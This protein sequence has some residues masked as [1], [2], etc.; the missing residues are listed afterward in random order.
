MAK[1]LTTQQAKFCANY[2]ESGNAFE[3]A[4][5]A[6]YSHST[7]NNATA[8]LIRKNK[9]IAE[10]IEKSQQDIIKASNWNKARIISELESIYLQAKQA[11]Q[12][13]NASKIL[14]LL[15]KLC[16]AMPTAQTKEINHNVKFETLLKDITPIN[17]TISD[18]YSAKL[19]N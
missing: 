2:I 9:G 3:S 15:A 7:A 13:G 12:I 11:D 17:K 10:R 18:N 14:E 6:G 16:N 5:K 19:V 4:K 8:L 1:Q